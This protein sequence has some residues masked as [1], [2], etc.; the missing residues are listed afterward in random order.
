MINKLTFSILFVLAASITIAQQ[1]K[2]PFEKYG[3]AEGLPEEVAIN[4]IQDDKGFIWFGT[5]NG[6]VKYDGYS[7]KVFKA[8]SNKTDSTILQMRSQWGGLIKA[9]DGKIWIAGESSGITSFD[10]IT[11]KFQNFYT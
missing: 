7:F 5:Q 8:S 11:E 6:L 1:N 2:I 3:V 10:P 9:K 4:P